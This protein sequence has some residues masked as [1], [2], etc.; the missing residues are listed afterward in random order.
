MVTTADKEVGISGRCVADKVISFSEII[1]IMGL[2][3]MELKS[4]C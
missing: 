4:P 1:K 3:Q 2:G